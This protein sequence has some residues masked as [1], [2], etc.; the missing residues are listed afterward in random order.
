MKGAK[1]NAA[2]QTTYTGLLIAGVFGAICA[3][4]GLVMVRSK[5]RGE[6]KPLLEEPEAL[7]L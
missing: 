2:Q 5:S 3:T 4:V 1:K 6:S 7:M